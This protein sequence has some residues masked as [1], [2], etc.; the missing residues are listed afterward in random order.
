MGEYNAHAPYILGQEWVPIRYAPYR[1]DIETETG[2]TFRIP[3][4]TTIVTGAYYLDNFVESGIN[5]MTA[6]M[7]VYP[8]GQETLTGPIK[9]LTIP[10][11]A[12]TTLFGTP[13]LNGAV[14]IVDAL[15]LPDDGKSVAFDDIPGVTAF[16]MFFDVDSFATELQGKRIL[17]VDL[18]YMASG[19]PPNTA[20]RTLYSVLELVATPSSRAFYS[21]TPELYASTG[22]ATRMLRVGMGN[23]NHFT[24]ITPDDQRRYPW[25]LQDLQRI[26][27]GAPAATRLELVWESTGTNA[28]IN[29]NISMTYSAL[30]VTYCEET[31]VAYGGWS[32]RKSS[33]FSDLTTQVPF[34]A[35]QNIVHLRTAATGA[36]TGTAL[37]AGEYTV[38]VGVADAGPSIQNVGAKP[39]I[40]A[41]HELYG[42]PAHT[43]VQVTRSLVLD[44]T[45]SIDTVN[46]LPQLSLHTSSAAVTGVH[47]YGVQVKAPVYAGNDVT[48]DVLQ[49]AGASGVSFPQVRFYAR[50]Y[51]TASG[52]LELFRTATPT[53]TVNITQADFDALA[54]IMNGWREVNLRFSVVPTFDN[55]GSNSE[56]TWRA[57]AAAV[58]SQ[59][60]ILVA[61]APS[62][63][64]TGVLNIDQTTYGGRGTDVS[65]LG[66]E[67]DSADAVLLFSQDPPA[68]TGL[69]VSVQ[70][71]TLTTGQECLLPPECVPTG[72]Y[73]HRVTW[74]PV[75]SLPATGFGYYELQRQD[76]VDTE[77][78]TVLRATSTA[79]TGYSDYEARVGLE[80]RYR[81]RTAN[82]LDFFGAWSATASST[83]TTPGV[84]GVADSGNSVLIFTTNH[85]QDGSANLAYVEVW[86]GAVAE[87]V[88]F[89]EA[90]RVR[91]NELYGRDYAVAFRTAE[92]GGERF[93]RTMLVQNSAVSTGRMRDGFTSLR[94]MAWQDSPYVCVRNELG[95]RWLATVLVP[96]GSIRRN[97]QLYMARVD[98]IEV[99]VTPEIVELP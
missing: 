8:R 36:T 2:H 68:V 53:Q 59:W 43:G 41:L 15:L 52:T 51:G 76:D 27:S 70:T 50:R 58:G 86:N 97:R 65:Y 60:Q 81:I 35:G 96:G 67:D 47:G 20:I 37:A 33:L 5:M 94:D 24:G 1:M 83:L 74:L 89:P 17:N 29:D 75:T 77:W 34:K 6:L 23:V 42:M 92:R 73:Y 88:Q 55:S 11:N 21:L 32:G 90:D 66:V 71:Q 87:D 82:V 3:T 98:I 38:T 91:I 30:E 40:R 62:V 31:R 46:V 22:N 12:T 80:S 64:G 28:T 18:V 84:L 7:S 10:V 48:Q 54:E 49:H 45:P 16:S 44:D 4:S 93:S 26:Q 69:G 99:T 61:D 63:T 78:N 56:W 9:K 85:L 39:V 14:S 13:L 95:D 19:P 25:R 79:V 57:A 72:L